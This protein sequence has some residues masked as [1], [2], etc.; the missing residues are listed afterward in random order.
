MQVPLKRG[1]LLSIGCAAI[2]PTDAGEHRLVI[3]APAAQP[4][5]ARFLILVV[6]SR[7]RR[8]LVERLIVVGGRPIAFV[9]AMVAMLALAAGSSVTHAAGTGAASGWAAKG[10]RVVG[11]PVAASG[12]VLVLTQGPGRTVW[13]EA[14]N[15]K[16]GRL[17]W[18]VAE[19][20]S[21]ITAGVAAV[22]ESAQRVVLAL[23]P[24]GGAGAGA[25]TLEGLDVATGRVLWRSP[26]PTLVVDAP[27]TCPK[28]L[29]A[30]AFCLVVAGSA[31]GQTALLALAPRTGK[32]LAAI[33]NI[34]RALGMS[35]GLYETTASTATFAQVSTPGGVT[36]SKPASALFGAGYNPNYGWIFDRLGALQVGSIGKAST[37]RSQDLSAT[38]TVGFD[39]QTGRLR[40]REPGEFECGGVSLLRVPY[41]CLM[42]GKATQSGPTSIKTSP[43]SSLTIAGFDPSNGH[44]TWRYPVS[45]LAEVLAGKVTIADDH[46][47]LVK[48]PSKGTQVLNLR[49]GHA[50]KPRSGPVYWCGHLNIF[51]VATGNAGLRVGSSLFTRCDANGRIPSPVP[52]GLGGASPAAAVGIRI[53]KLFVWA[54]PEGLHAAA[55]SSR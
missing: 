32:P 38:E 31:P 9:T 13:L 10:L 23:V 36:W 49:T 8:L 5:P 35:A 43:G 33:A 28:P 45:N 11:G 30:A 17:Q 34:E 7:V 25:V 19:S 4:E 3:G 42:K 14:L 12:Q 40:W 50:T 41:L 53:G 16:T 18:K 47:L 48:S 20:F 15:A 27:S 21:D 6:G 22:P 44:V 54:G 2:M 29:G 46:S 52:S 1:L 55:A 26:Q 51:H 39:A 24:A 37:G